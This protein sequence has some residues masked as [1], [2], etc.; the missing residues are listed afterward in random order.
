MLEEVSLKKR[1]IDKRANQTC[2]FF[3]GI[4]K[5][6]SSE[7]RAAFNQPALALLMVVLVYRVCSAAVAANDLGFSQ[8]TTTCV[9][10][11]MIRGVFVPVIGCA[12]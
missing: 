4:V 10:G 5:N 11:P 12:E 6:G 1:T 7:R 9:R 2:L 3:A 8:S